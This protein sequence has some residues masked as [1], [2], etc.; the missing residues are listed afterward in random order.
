MGDFTLEHA[1]KDACIPTTFKYFP[2]G[3]IMAS[4]LESVPTLCRRI[5]NNSANSCV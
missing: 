5:N 4:S 3:E 1:L 2:L